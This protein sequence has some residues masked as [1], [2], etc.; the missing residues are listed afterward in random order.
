MHETLVPVFGIV[1]SIG[2]PVLIV[3]LVMINRHRRNLKRQEA[4]TRAA[5]AGRSV[6]EIREMLDALSTPPKNG[7]GKAWLKSGVII[8]GGG[9]GV[10]LIGLITGDKEALGAAAFLFV[11]GLSFVLAW[12]LADR[13]EP[14]SSA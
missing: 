4:V 14:G 2:G 12:Y 13:K 3:A 5:E 1:F 11:L 10:S 7:K 8:A 9:A 6:Q